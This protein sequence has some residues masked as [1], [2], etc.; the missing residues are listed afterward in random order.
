MY[1]KQAEVL[2]A[3]RSG[4][5]VATW[6]PTQDSGGRP[7]DRFDL[8]PLCGEARDLAVAVEATSPEAVQAAEAYAEEHGWVVLERPAALQKASG[9]PRWWAES[10]DE[11][12][13][14]RGRRQHKEEWMNSADFRRFG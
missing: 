1:T 2:E 8:V 11:R 14:E 7:G 13:L 9:L 10:C 3:L 4:T 6:R 5:K 12:A